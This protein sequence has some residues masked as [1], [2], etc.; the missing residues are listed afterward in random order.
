MPD[1]AQ[2]FACNY[3]GRLRWVSMAPLAARLVPAVWGSAHLKV[4]DFAASQ[5]TKALYEAVLG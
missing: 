2:S 3:T 5:V 1:H 4:S